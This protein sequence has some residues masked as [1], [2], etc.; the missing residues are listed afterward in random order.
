MHAQD[1]LREILKQLHN[2]ILVNVNKKRRL[3]R[4]LTTLL[5][6]GTDLAYN[7][8]SVPFHTALAYRNSILPEIIHIP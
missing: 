6:N 7:R 4:G 5:K 8:F 1:F 3:L 2:V